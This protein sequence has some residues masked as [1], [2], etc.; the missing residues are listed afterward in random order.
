MLPH[1]RLSLVIFTF[2][3]H[4][5]N[6]DSFYDRHCANLFYISSR[7]E[8]GIQFYNGDQNL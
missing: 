2:Y 8:A 3:S 1:F 6:F 7:E 4:V 5:Y